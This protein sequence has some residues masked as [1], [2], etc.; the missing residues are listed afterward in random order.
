[1]VGQARREL[2]N[3]LLRERRAALEAL[4]RAVDQGD[5]EAIEAALVEA[6]RAEIEKDEIKK[7]EDKL[8]QLRSL[9]DEQKAEKIA[10][11]EERAKKKDAFLFVKKDNAE[12]LSELLDGLAEGTRWQDWRDQA[13]R[14]LQRFA[15]DLKSEN[16][17]AMLA[18]RLGDGKADTVPGWKAAAA[19]AQRARGNT[20]VSEQEQAEVQDIAAEAGLD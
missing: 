10:R 14:K 2:Q 8:E 3:I 11:E 17:Q 7:A 18:A 9:T 15:Q 13:G 19:H 16:V 1:M 4:G 20:E 5:E 12:K 6:R